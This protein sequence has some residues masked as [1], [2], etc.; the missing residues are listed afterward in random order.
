[1]TNN[2]SIPRTILLALLLLAV[3]A[4]SL[5]GQQ[6]DTTR[7]VSSQKTPVRHGL[8]SNPGQH[9]DD[10]LGQAQAM[11]PATYDRMEIDESDLPKGARDTTTLTFKDTDLRDIFRAIALQ[12]DLNLFLDNGIGKRTTISLSKVRVFDAIKFLCDQNGLKLTFEGGIF[13][14]APPPPPAAPAPPPPKVPLVGYENGLL[15]VML[16]DDD[17]EK[18]IL[19]IQ[20]KTGRNILII[21][22]T[23]GTVTGK[24]MDIEFDIGFTQLMNNNGFAVQKRNG[25]YVVSRLE[26]YVGTQGNAT[27][28]KSGPYWVSV[29]D[30]L[31]T[32]DVTN[33]PIERVLTDMIRQ[34]NTDL[35]MYSQLTGNVTARATTLSL[36]K[37]LDMILRNTAYTYRESEGVYFVG[38][39]T[40]KAL[41][42]TKLIRLNYLR[43]EQTLEMIPQSI[44]SQASLK[45]MKEHN[46]LL[47]IASNDILQ[48]LQEVLA[49]L[50]K[51]VPQVL[52]EAIV[53]DYDI[54]KGREF[55]IDA[56]LLGPSDTTHFTRKGMLWPGIDMTFGG[57]SVNR[58]LQKAKKVKLFGTE[59]DLASLGVLPDDFYL[60]LRA[61]EKDGLANVK[62]RPVIATLNG[63]KATL[64]IGTTQ[65]YLLKTTTPYRDNNNQTVFQ[66]TQTFHTIQADVKL[67]ITPFVGAEGFVTLDIKPDFKTPVGQFSSEI[68]P[69]I[70]S[71]SLSSTVVV[72]EGETIVLGGLIQEGES[73]TSTKVPILGSIPL[74]GKLFSSTE[75]TTRKSE[76][77]IYVTPH[78]S[79]GEAFQQ[80][81]QYEED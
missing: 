70:N 53:V 73:E 39:K 66:E 5:Y 13:R 34:L 11:R 29:K 64:S 24:L 25:I 45:V 21:S 42:M 22:G 61:L 4:G 7:K 1:M 15:S 23:T 50:D 71:R 68:P 9:Q 59:I 40:N 37:A 62:S 2:N 74:L 38:E 8:P 65:Y 31:V 26:Y 51:P 56:G 63:H 80:A 47:A 54:T 72:K 76:L 28:Q 55:G 10:S 14:V 6:P 77:L 67:E 79:Y 41:V 30:S 35:V 43:A 46:A 60:R 49:Q 52:I 78:I 32:I 48:Q 57:K 12:H 36:P 81:Y 58:M 17:L 33:A 18:V 27:P 20:H 16:K 44:A 75:S 19:E 3:V 69:T